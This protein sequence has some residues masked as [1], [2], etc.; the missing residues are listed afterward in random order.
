M[1]DIAQRGNRL[2]FA[3]GGTVKRP[4][5]PSTHAKE[6][7][8]QAAEG[9]RIGLK[10]G[11]MPWGTGPKPGTIEFL[12]HT[13][14]TPKRKRKTI[15]GVI[16]GAKKVVKTIVDKVRK[17]KGKKGLGSGIKPSEMHEI[18]PKGDRKLYLKEKLANP[19]KRFGKVEG[20]RIGKV[21]GGGI[22]KLAETA[23]KRWKKKKVYPETESLT[24]QVGPYVGDVGSEGKKGRPKV[25]KGRSPG[26]RSWR[27]RE[28]GPRAGAKK[29]EKA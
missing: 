28:A 25:G 17:E 2:T 19:H 8:T 21:V 20:G 15:G 9:G 24:H 4:K 16:K 22:K 10:K 5:K 6:V 3:K 29:G 7:P 23:S 13:T 18:I 26:R 14:Q 27:D 11:K 1:G 12:Q